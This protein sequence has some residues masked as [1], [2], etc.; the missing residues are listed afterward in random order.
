MGSES[1]IKMWRDPWLIGN[2]NSY[3]ELNVIARFEDFYVA[4]LI[5]HTTRTWNTSL[6]D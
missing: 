6:M 3:V 4:N 1:N 2:I 5:D